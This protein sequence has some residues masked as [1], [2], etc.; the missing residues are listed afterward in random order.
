ML[1][2]IGLDRL[3]TLNNSD[4]FFISHRIQEFIFC[5]QIYVVN[6]SKIVVFANE[7]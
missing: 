1:P 6:R 3:D 7:F 5:N 4:D 2:H